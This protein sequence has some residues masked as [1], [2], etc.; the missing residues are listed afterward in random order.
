MT[1]LNLSDYKLIQPTRIKKRKGNKKMYDIEVKDDHTFFIKTDN[2]ELLSHNCDGS[3]ITALII[4]FLYKWFPYI[5]KNGNLFKLV[6][7]LL[8]GTYNGQRKYFYSFD[9][10]NKF[11]ETK[12]LTNINYL[13]GLGSLNIED[14]EY[15]MANRIF[16]NIK[17]DKTT[18]KFLE[19]AFGDSANNRKIWLQ[20]K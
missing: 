7:P 9:E 6:T 1:N 4:N 10:Y 3:H 20:N 19:I 16:Y 2:C 17:D 12:K 5:I 8:V 11:N 13:K 14:W 18:A 15:V